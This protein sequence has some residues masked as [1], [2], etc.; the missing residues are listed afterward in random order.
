ML[1]VGGHV[2][3]MEQDEYEN[4]FVRFDDSGKIVAVGEGAPTPPDGEEVIDVKGG[5]IVPGF[6]DAHSHIGLW[7]D[8]LTFEGADGNEDSD[9]ITP[10]MRAIDG[11]NP[12]DKAF[13]E[14]RENGITSVLTGPGSAN[15]I[16]GQFAALKTAGLCVDDMIIKAPAFMKMALGENPK[17]VYH[18]KHQAPVTRMGTAALLRETLYA[19]K[20]YAEKWNRYHKDPEKEDRPDFDFRL[21]ALVPVVEGKLPVKIHAHRAD[22]I[23]TALRLAREFHFD[24]SIEH[25]TDGHLMKDELKK[26]NVSVCVGPFLGDRSKPELKNLSLC[27]ANVLSDAGVPVAIITDH[28]ETPE[29]FLPLCAAM[30]IKEGMKPMAALASITS[31]AA[32]VSGIDARVGSLKPGKDADILVF[33]RFPLDFEASLLN[34]F[35]DGKRMK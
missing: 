25:A 27:T 14:A 7:E 29:K 12:M 17:S 9:P 31:V 6:V 4:G 15:P 32:K 16:G 20:E 8:S 3:T 11:V 24:L 23:F 30:A 10:Q 22:D 2:L 5:Y 18:D 33:D 1:L 35:I 19:A 28:P 21:E 13:R 26:A 34:V